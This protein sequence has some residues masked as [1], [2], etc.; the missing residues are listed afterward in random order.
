MKI[1]LIDRSLY[2]KG[3]LLLIRKDQKIDS[4]EK[5]LMMRIGKILGFEKS[6]CE[7]AVNEILENPYIVDEPP[8]FSKPSVAKCFI[9]DGLRLSII[10]EQIHETE[11]AWL[12]AVASKN[13]V[14]NGWLQNAVERSLTSSG[15]NLE[16]DLEANRLEWD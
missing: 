10:D 13:G 12:R 3:L 2:F 1:S 5:N 6:F 11:L 4:N 8:K 14:E 7:N 15:K 16:N 9:K